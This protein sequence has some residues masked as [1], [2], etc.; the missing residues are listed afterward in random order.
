[1]SYLSSL[2][3]KVFCGSPDGTISEALANL[4]IVESPGH[5]R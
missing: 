2:T 4:S 3:S 1:M 5:N